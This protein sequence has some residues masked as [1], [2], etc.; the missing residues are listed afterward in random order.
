MVWSIVCRWQGLH[1]LYQLYCHPPLRTL[2]FRSRPPDWLG[3]DSSEEEC[4]LTETDHLV[5]PIVTAQ[6]DVSLDVGAVCPGQNRRSYQRFYQALTAQWLAVEMLWLARISVYDT[7]SDQHRYFVQ[8]WKIWGDNRSRTLQEKLDVLEIFDF[9]WS[10]LGRKSFESIAREWDRLTGEYTRFEDGGD[11]FRSAHQPGCM[12][13]VTQYLRPP[14]IIELFLCSTRRPSH[15]WSIK[16]LQYLRTLG[17]FDEK[18]GIC[19][20]LD[21]SESSDFRWWWY[22]PVNL[23]E[24]DVLVGIQTSIDP[25]SCPASDIVLE[26]V[27]GTYRHTAWDFDAKGHLFFREETSERIFSRM[28]KTLAP[29]LRSH[30]SNLDNDVNVPAD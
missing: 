9:V 19:R 13:A 25:N 17:F 3:S 7:P 16:R 1:L 11:D 27:W 30:L 12:R 22:C 28:A 29:H 26:Y 5:E 6:G 10:F 18:N 15:S 4:N 24:H 2:Y 14:N 21:G 23:L 20:R 8:V